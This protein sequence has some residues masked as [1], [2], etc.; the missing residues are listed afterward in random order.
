MF[1]SLHAIAAADV[2]EHFEKVQR[3]AS[4]SFH[5]SKLFNGAEDRAD[6]ASLRLAKVLLPCPLFVRAGGA[7]FVWEA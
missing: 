2:E 3:C 5:P 4:P 1:E 6:C 7:I